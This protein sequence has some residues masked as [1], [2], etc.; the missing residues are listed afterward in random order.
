DRSEPAAQTPCPR[1]R[2][3]DRQ[4]AAGAVQRHHRR[5]RCAR[6]P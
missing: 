3:R 2:D 5:R 4:P 1:C 6:R